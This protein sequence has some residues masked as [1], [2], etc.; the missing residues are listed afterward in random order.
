MKVP[1][2]FTVL[3]KAANRLQQFLILLFRYSLQGGSPVGFDERF[4]LRSEARSA[5]FRQNC[6]DFRERECFS[7]F[8]NCCRFFC[9][10]SDGL[11]SAHDFLPV[12]SLLR[13]GSRYFSRWG[14]LIAKRSLEII[15]PL[16]QPLRN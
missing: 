3:P 8:L 6:S 9:S 4:H 14:F 7:L 2:R 11:F 16:T 5:L 15:R 13:F 1:I 12:R 10:L